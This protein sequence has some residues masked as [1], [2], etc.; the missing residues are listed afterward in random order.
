M[1]RKTLR[2][3]SPSFCPRS[4]FPGRALT[5]GQAGTSS[6]MKAIMVNPYN[7]SP[8]Q[9]DSPTEHMSKWGLARG[10]GAGIGTHDLPPH[11]TLMLLLGCLGG[12]GVGSRVPR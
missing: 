5:L 9:N 10:S 3:G 4:S 11:W 7:S 12:D 1:L 2:G 6:C 8:A